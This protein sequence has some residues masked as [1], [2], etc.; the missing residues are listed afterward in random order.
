M[1]ECLT[2]TLMHMGV[3]SWYINRVEFDLHYHLKE[4]L[5]SNCCTFVSNC[6][7]VCVIHFERGRR[8]LQTVVPLCLNCTCV[9][10]IHV[11]RGRRQLNI[12]I[13]QQTC[14]SFLLKH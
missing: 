2:G 6:T 7:C 9:C 13:V 3:K 1:V 12:C 11:E 10:V 8:Q 5:C 4:N 14:F